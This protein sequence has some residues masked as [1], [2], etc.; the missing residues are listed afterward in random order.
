[1]HEKVKTKIELAKCK[2]LA[3]SDLSQWDYILVN[4]YT[5]Q[6]LLHFISRDNCNP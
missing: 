4:Y 5:E 2:K 3:L 6:E 1:M